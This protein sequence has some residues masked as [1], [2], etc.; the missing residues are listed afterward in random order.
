MVGGQEYRG[1][2]IALALVITGAM[3]M[4]A[5]APS[6]VTDAHAQTPSRT[7]NGYEVS[8]RFLDEWSRR[9]SDT[10]NVY[11]NGL[12]ITQRRTEISLEDGKAYET[13]WFERARYEAHPENPRPHDVLLGRLGAWDTEGRGKIDSFTGKVV[14][15]ADAAFVGVERPAD[16]GPRKL[17]FPETRHS[18][19]DALLDYW[20]R[21]GGLA[22]FGYPLSEPFTETSRA[23]G[24]PYTVQYF[25]RACMELHPEKPGPYSVEL[26]L[27]GV[28]QVGMRAVP[29]DELPVAPP[30]GV[31]TKK[32]TIKIASIVEPDDISFITA[33][34]NSIAAR[35]RSLVEDGMVGRD[36][37]ENLFPLNA[38][39][40]PTLE[41][42]G[43][44]FMGE[45]KDRYLQVKYKL[46]QGI[47]WSDGH[48]VT[49]SD[50]V[51][52]FT[53]TCDP[54]TPLGWV[55]LRPVCVQLQSVDNPDRHTVIYNFKSFKE[56]VISYRDAMHPPES[57]LP[58]FFAEKPVVSRL[59]SSIGSILPEHVLKAIP[60]E[61]LPS[62][63]YA[64]APIGTGPWRV[65]RWPRGQEIVFVPNEHYSL[66]A[67]P[68]IKR[69]EVKF[70]GDISSTMD[71]LYKTGNIDIVASEAYTTP[72]A[73]KA[74][75]EAAGGRIVS[76]PSSLWE[77]LSFY[78]DYPPFQDRKVREAITV[79]VNRQRVVDVAF[80][81]VG[82]VAN[83]VIPSTVSLSLEHSDFARKYP[84]IAAKYKL[85]LYA[86]NPARAVQL[87]EEAGWSCPA[88]VTNTANCDNKPRE[89][90]GQKLQFEYATTINA[91]RQ[92][93]QGL[94]QSDLRAVGIDAQ[95]KSY[96][97][98]VFFD[99][100]GP[101]SD[102]TTKLAQ[103]AWV[104]SVGRDFRAWM[105]EEVYNRV[106]N[107][108]QNEQRYC[109]SAVDEANTRFDTSVGSEMVE[110][111]AE[112][113]VILMQDLPTIPLVQRPKVEVVTATLENY[114]LPGG[115]TSSFWNARQ[116]W[117]K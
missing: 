88:G 111:A 44:R 39:Y 108:G 20:T 36:D 97:S 2:E 12:P 96:P 11:V 81:G 50:A 67:K 32:D 47:K 10:L 75:I 58:I 51:F 64:R 66:T 106:T 33:S 76:R 40:V 7:I 82:S 70:V 63:G 110:A 101:R 5:F 117:F 107:T 26:G 13:Q 54:S 100:P 84:D 27:L 45:G 17:W 72:P 16:L 116:W 57:L 21:Y 18:L 89:K 49:S 69:I 109:N 68:S 78:L 52:A 24:K 62:S 19:S 87:L 95:I 59:Y 48:E 93:T 37:N 4:P 55:W 92:Q 6:S 8:G 83:G 105:C 60:P 71:S 79:A 99:A 1:R 46:R 9:G 103:F 77:H 61:Q 90:G 28:E 102:G 31:T 86:Y 80:R 34:S 56:F 43:A 3:L 38:W 91:V 94:V 30:K 113:Q 29:A 41:N 74:G 98:G 112:A 42:G 85:P 114:K 14:R 73:D 104:G 53:L 23:D 35:L 22:Q 15:A 115:E 65:E 25:E